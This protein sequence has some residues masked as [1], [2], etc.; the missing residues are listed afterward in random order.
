MQHIL[1]ADPRLA[2]RR[3][4]GPAL[5]LCLQPVSSATGRPAL[6]TGWFAPA[7]DYLNPTEQLVLQEFYLRDSQRSGA[8]ARLQV[9]LGYSERRVT[10]GGGDKRD[11]RQIPGPR[12]GSCQAN[13]DFRSFRGYNN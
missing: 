13:E 2:R 10:V 5:L 6:L 9:R 8:T 7:C 12:L 1:A 11:Q 3:L 4:P